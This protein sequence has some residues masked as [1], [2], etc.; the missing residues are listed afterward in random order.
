MLSFMS[1][2]S[3]RSLRIFRSAC[4]E[5]RKASTNEYLQGY[6]D[7]ISVLILTMAPSDNDDLERVESATEKLSLHRLRD[8]MG[9]GLEPLLGMLR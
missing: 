1:S 8:A 3:G 7:I 6:H 4:R 2:E 9:P 5:T